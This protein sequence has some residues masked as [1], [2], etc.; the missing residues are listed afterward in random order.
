[1]AVNKVHR[2]FYQVD[3]N[4]GWETLPGYPAGIQQKILSGTLDTTNKKGSYTRLLRFQPGAFSTKPFVH[5]YWEEVFFLEG[6][7]AVG[8]D[9][10][11]NGGTVFTKNTYCV[12]PPGVSHGPF[13]SKNGC[14]LLESHYYDPP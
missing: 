3:M 7:L 8:S 2:E 9:D 6:D 11:G 12:R 10:K 14:L 4:E 13:S 1:M 5:D